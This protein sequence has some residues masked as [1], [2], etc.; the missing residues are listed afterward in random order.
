VL[1]P[2]STNTQLSNSITD[3]IDVTKMLSI[4]DFAIRREWRGGR[5]TGQGT[6]RLKRVFYIEIEVCSRCGV[7]GQ[8]QR[9]MQSC[10]GSS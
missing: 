9:L 8:E 10:L 3:S 2:L 1:I 7:V 6:Q 5:D 4:N